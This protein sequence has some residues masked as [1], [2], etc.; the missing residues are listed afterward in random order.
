MKKIREATNEELQDFPT[1]LNRLMSF[2]KNNWTGVVKPKGYKKFL[3]EHYDAHNVEYKDF[4]LKFD[5]FDSSTAGD[6]GIHSKLN[7]PNVACN[8]REGD[9]ST[10]ESLISA[11]LSYGILIGEERGKRNADSGMRENFLINVS[12]L[13]KD[14][15][16][17]NTTESMKER[18]KRQLLV[19]R[20]LYPQIFE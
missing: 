19:M 6:I 16:M 11:C 4:I 12:Y 7:L 14:V 8:E 9:M 3:E 20:S 18:A 13:L 15:E 10:T 17:G 1:I 5:G 2:I